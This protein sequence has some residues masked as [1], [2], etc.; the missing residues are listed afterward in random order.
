MKWNNLCCAKTIAN[1]A[2]GGDLPAFSGSSKRD[3]AR[4]VF[5]PSA[6]AIPVKIAIARQL[7]TETTVTLEMDRRKSRN[8]RMDPRLP[9]AAPQTQCTPVPKSQY[10]VLTL[11]PFLRRKEQE[12]VATPMPSCK[13]RPSKAWLACRLRQVTPAVGLT[14]GTNFDPTAIGIGNGKTGHP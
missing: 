3:G 8:G 14:A 1:R 4:P 11:S 12:A 5:V 6:R 13:P 10:A 9:P 7:R 2:G